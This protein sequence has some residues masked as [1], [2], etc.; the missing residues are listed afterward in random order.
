MGNSRSVLEQIG[1]NLNESLGARSVEV[2]PPLSPAP[3]PR[4][5]GR[6]PAR[7]FG[8]IDVTRVIPDPGQPREEFSKDAIDRLAKSIQEKG[9]LSPIR[10]R[11]SD[12]HRK[13]MII[14]GERRWRATVQAGLPTIECFFHE[15]ELAP[16]E[17][18]QQQLIEN[19][20]REDLRPVEEARAFE[21][22][23]HQSG[24]TQK[25]L[26]T[27]LRISETRVTRALALLKLDPEIQLQVEQKQIS[28][29]A[30]Y[31]I[32]RVSNPSVQ[33][34]LA[35]KAAKESLS[36]G[37]TTRAV[38]QRRGRRQGPQ[39]ATHL[40]FPTEDG[41][42][43]IVQSKRKGCYEEVEQALVTAL[44]EVRHRIRNR[45]QIF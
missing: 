40:T 10:V 11:W 5:A 21:K 26:A 24:G 8:R 6:R 19:C 27:M 13:W 30:A 7:E 23:R 28:A 18:L 1:G 22:L 20:L 2:T 17:I 32:S 35:Q 9:Q 41:W 12:E 38:R 39:R 25:D 43:V 4:D 31:E 44:E 34:A 37:Q 45:V 33:K 15:G 14:A 36:V 29:R 16:S 42:K 3:T